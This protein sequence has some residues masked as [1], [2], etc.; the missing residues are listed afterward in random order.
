M[1]KPLCFALVV[2]TA[3]VA[4]PSQTIEPVLDG[5][6]CIVNFDE[7]SCTAVA[8]CSWGPLRYACPANAF[9]YCPPGE[10]D[11]NQRGSASQFP[12]ATCSCGGNG[13]Y[14]VEQIGGP[15]MAAGQAAP[16]TCVVVGTPEVFSCS[17]IKDQGN[18]SLSPAIAGL[19]ICDNGVR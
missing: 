12:Q 4:H 2:A 5:D 15:A 8:G 13:E 10:C 9:T 19:C 11:G 6:T 17:L 1:T 14:C 18:C 16:I 7:A 3:C